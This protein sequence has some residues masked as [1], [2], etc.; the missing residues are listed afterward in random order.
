M[1]GVGWII[2]S[3]SIMNHHEGTSEVLFPGP[4]L[5]TCHPHLLLHPQYVSHHVVPGINLLGYVLEE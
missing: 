5:T 2:T 3:D 4:P 1:K